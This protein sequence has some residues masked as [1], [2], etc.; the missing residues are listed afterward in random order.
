MP[1]VEVAGAALQHAASNSSVRIGPLPGRRRVS[2]LPA[3]SFVLVRRGSGGGGCIGRRLH[4]RGRL[5]A[6]VP[7]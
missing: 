4:E 1:V 3:F 7:A 6:G 5:L 2:F